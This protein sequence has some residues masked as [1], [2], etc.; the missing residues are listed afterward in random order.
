MIKKEYPYRLWKLG[1]DFKRYAEL[2]FK[3]KINGAGSR[4]L[5]FMIGHSFELI[6]KSFLLTK[7]IE[8]KTLK[9]NRYG[10]NLLKLFKLAMKYKE[11][12]EIPGIK[13]IES[14]VDSLSAYY[15]AKDFEY[16]ETGIMFVKH[17]KVLFEDFD[18]L[19]KICE[20]TCE[21]FINKKQS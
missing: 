10:H 9:K 5:Y 11:F 2:I 21:A 20:K 15:E 4:P 8:L 17:P 7:G 16:I 6:L 3:N 19:S 18:F 13:E 14:R 1:K 12:Q